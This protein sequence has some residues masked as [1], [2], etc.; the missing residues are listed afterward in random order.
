M[1]GEIYGKLQHERQVSYVDQWKL[2]DSRRNE[3]DNE[4][5]YYPIVELKIV[6]RQPAL[7]IFIKVKTTGTFFMFSCSK[8]LSII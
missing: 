7:V 6:L 2:I 4:M 1:N 5:G 3:K 8:C